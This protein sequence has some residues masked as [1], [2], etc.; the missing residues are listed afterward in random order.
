MKPIKRL[1]TS[2]VYQTSSFVRYFV[3]IQVAIR[4]RV[5]AAVSIFFGEKCV[6]KGRKEVREGIMG[7]TGLKV[8]AFW[9][10]HMDRQAPAN[11]ADSI[12]R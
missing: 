4:I 1:Q 10:W 5:A 11:D 2:V 12:S 7:P 9:G 8:R 6:E 3:P